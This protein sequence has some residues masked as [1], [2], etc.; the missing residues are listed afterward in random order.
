MK[1]D[2][3]FR[4]LVENLANRSE[5]TRS[6]KASFDDMENRWQKTLEAGDAI[7]IHSLKEELKN[8]SGVI[9]KTVFANMSKTLEEAAGYLDIEFQELPELPPMSAYGIFNENTKLKEIPYYK[10]DTTTMDKVVETMKN[11]SKSIT[12]GLLDLVKLLENRTHD[13]MGTDPATKEAALK[14]KSFLDL[15]NSSDLFKPRSIVER[16]LSTGYIYAGDAVIKQNND[17]VRYKEFCDI[18]K[19][20][21]EKLRILAARFNKPDVPD[22][23]FEMSE[24]CRYLHLKVISIVEGLTGRVL[25]MSYNLKCIKDTFVEN[26]KSLN[27]AILSFKNN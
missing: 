26:Y 18:V 3:N 14:I 27:D 13:L 25:A 22:N 7:D 15:V 21:P 5:Y 1:K 23:F 24:N 17:K 11:D 9:T 6:V 8:D 19:T 12:T 10:Y 4:K 16:S 20:I 2:L